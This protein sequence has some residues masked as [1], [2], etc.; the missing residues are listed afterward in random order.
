MNPSNKFS[1][2]PLLRGT[3]LQ[4]KV[5]IVTG[6]GAGIGKATAHVLAQAGCR[7]VIG[8]IVPERGEG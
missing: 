8:E 4:G 6:A 2:L 3:D 5:A 1:N 7:I